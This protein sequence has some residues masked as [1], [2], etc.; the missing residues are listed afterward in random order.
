VEAWGVD[1]TFTGKYLD[2]C[3]AGERQALTGTGLCLEMNRASVRLA[4][5]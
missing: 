1:L 3:R 4:G 2:L 5:N